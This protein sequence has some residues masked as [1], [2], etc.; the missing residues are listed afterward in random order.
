MC[1]CVCVCVCVCEKMAPWVSLHAMQ[2]QAWIQSELSG[3]Q[4][5]MAVGSCGPSFGAETSGR[6]REITKVCWPASLARKGKVLG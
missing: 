2:A 5:G 4:Q 6:V 3:R 1:V